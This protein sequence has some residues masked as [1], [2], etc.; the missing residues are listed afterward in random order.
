MYEQELLENV[1]VLIDGR[2]ELNKR[3]ITLKLRGSSNQCILYKGT[4]F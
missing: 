1:D 2:F 4:D 3:D